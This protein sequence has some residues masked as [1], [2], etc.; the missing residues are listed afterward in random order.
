MNVTNFYNVMTIRQ[1]QKQFPSIHWLEYIN[2]LIAP[3]YQVTT[4]ER[5]LV[6]VPDYIKK[7]EDLLQ[8]TSKE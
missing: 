1:M 2:N 7:L 4:N 6:L 3:H 5:I 8:N